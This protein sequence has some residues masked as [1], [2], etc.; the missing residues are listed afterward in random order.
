MDIKVIKIGGNVVENEAMLSRFVKD[1][2]AIKGAKIL[3]HGGGI[4]ASELQKALGQ[5]P[6]MIEGRRVTD[7]EALKAVTMT[8]AGWCNKHIV[9]LLQAAGCN[10]LGLCGA[11]A[12]VITAL[13]RPA[14][15]IDYGYVGDIVPEGI[16]CAILLKF[17]EAGIT[18]VLCAI[19][20][21]GKGN[22][23]N[24]NADTIASSVA[25]ALSSEADVD[26]VYCFEKN[27]VLSDKNDDNSVIETITPQYY[28]ELKASGTVADGMIPKLDNAF[29]AIEAGVRSVMIKHAGNLS[30]NIQ[31]TLKK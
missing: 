4:M 6:V 14:K 27:G 25:S 11:D 22:L 17:I 28:A 10:A 5:T 9:A 26:L 2:A 24:T 7:S 16:N 1:F 19:N 3:V 29:R 31:T 15:P 18:P 8:Y 12:N 23:L 21:D 13:K 30:N 20:H